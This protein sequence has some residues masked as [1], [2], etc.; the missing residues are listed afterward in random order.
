MELAR[1]GIARTPNAASET[2]PGWMRTGFAT[3]AALASRGYPLAGD[4]ASVALGQRAAMEVYP[5]A[6]FWLFAAARPRDHAGAPGRRA[7]LTRKRNARV[8]AIVADRL[9]LLT[10]EIRQRLEQ[11]PHFP[12]SATAR[13]DYIDASCAAAMGALALAGEARCMSGRAGEGGIWLPEWSV[14]AEPLEAS[15]RETRAPMAIADG[16]ITSDPAILQGK[17]AVRGTGISVAFVLELLAGMTKDEVLRDYPLLTSD[18]IDHALKYAAD[19]MHQE[20]GLRQVVGGAV[21]DVLSGS[22][23]SGGM[24]LLP[25]QAGGWTN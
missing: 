12:L 22:A 10:P 17:P 8:A 23:R 6:S 14:I 2:V 16:I 21:G 1:I 19:V 15:G 3:Y 25:H 11:H 18:D 13:I 24:L 7:P 5:D 4:A 20:R 9:P